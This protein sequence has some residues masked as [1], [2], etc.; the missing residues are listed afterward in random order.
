MKEVELK[1][2]KGKG[3]DSLVVDNR[4]YTEDILYHNKYNIIIS[5]EENYQK[6]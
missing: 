1:K 4:N 5:K 6:Q 3:Q 2:V